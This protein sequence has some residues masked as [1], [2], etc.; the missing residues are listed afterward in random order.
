MNE[1]SDQRSAVHNDLAQEFLLCTFRAVLYGMLYAY[2]LR[3]FID[4]SVQ[5]SSSALLIWRVFVLL[6]RRLLTPC[7]ESI[8]GTFYKSFK[9]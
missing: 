5:S 7:L 9:S 6:I 8:P 2:L 3:H 4:F 1:D